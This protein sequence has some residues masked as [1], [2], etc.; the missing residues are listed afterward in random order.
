MNQAA[1]QGNTRAGDDG[2]HGVLLPV[3]PDALWGHAIAWH[4]QCDVFHINCLDPN[5]L[6][7]F[8]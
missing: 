5:H 7:S 1:A 4:F 2:F 6:C 3:L 8:Q